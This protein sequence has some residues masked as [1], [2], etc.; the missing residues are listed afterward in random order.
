MRGPPPKSS[1]ASVA[2]P[3]FDTACL[4]AVPANPS[5]PAP[6]SDAEAPQSGSTSTFISM[7]SSAWPRWPARL[8]RRSRATS[9]AAAAAAAAA[10]SGSGALRFALELALLLIPA[11]DPIRGPPTT[12]GG[13]NPGPPVAGGVAGGPPATVPTAEVGAGPGAGAAAPVGAAM[14]TEPASGSIGGRA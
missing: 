11:P 1:P 13:T 6:W 8:R 4:C 2:K 5:D 10:L 9:R 14:G 7:N 3:D 12:Y